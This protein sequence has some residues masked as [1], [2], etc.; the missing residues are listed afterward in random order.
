MKV[1]VLYLWLKVPSAC[2]ASVGVFVLP[3]VIIQHVIKSCSWWQWR[4]KY[5]EFVLLWFEFL[6]LF[7]PFVDVQLHAFFFGSVGSC[8]PSIKFRARLKLDC[9]WT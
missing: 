1:Y 7:C 2:S 6:F 4:L 8:Q 9:P 3:V 5:K